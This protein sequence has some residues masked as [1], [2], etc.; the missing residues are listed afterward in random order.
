MIFYDAVVIDCGSGKH[1]SCPLRSV[2]PLDCSPET[3]IRFSLLCLFLQKLRPL[4]FVVLS[5]SHAC[6]PNITLN[7]TNSPQHLCATVITTWTQCCTFKP[8]RNILKSLES[9]LKGQEQW[10]AVAIPYFDY[11]LPD[12][13]SH[14]H[15][16]CQASCHKLHFHS[17]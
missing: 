17:Y 6:P 4:H 10:A 15:D 7:A 3:K 12:F 8:F 9:F 13:C 16:N 11:L 14:K 2:C 5:P 1:H